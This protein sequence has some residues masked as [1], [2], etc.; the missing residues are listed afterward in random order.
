MRKLL[1]FTKSS[2]WMFFLL[3]IANDLA[4]ALHSKDDAVALVNTFIADHKDKDVAAMI[5]SINKPKEENNYIKDELYIF[6]FD[7][8]AKCLAHATTP[9]LVGTDLSTLRDADG[10]LFMKIITDKVK[11]GIKEGWE[12]YKWTNPAIKK[13]QPKLTFF[14]EFKGI[15]IL[16]GIY[17]Q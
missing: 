2:F 16:A 7:I 8:S 9:G 1:S 12:D 17:K 14:K 13:I 6:L 15:I 4:Y 5:T 3:L 11:K 10:K